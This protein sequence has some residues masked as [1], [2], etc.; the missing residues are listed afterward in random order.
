[1]VSR[2]CICFAGCLFS[3]P[4]IYI[5]Y[6]VLIAVIVFPPSPFLPSFLSYFLFFFETSGVLKKVVSLVRC[7]T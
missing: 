5:D 7:I 4:F 3:I 2:D 6:I 1:M